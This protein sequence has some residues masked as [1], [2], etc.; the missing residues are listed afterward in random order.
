MTTLGGRRAYTRAELMDAYG[1][2]RSTLEKWYRERERTGHPE[3]AGT[4]G[5]QLV[6]DAAAWDDWYAARGPAVPSGAVS[7]D[8]L[9]ARHGLSRHRLKQLWAD[10]ASNGHPEPAHRA[11]K[12]LYWDE[13]EWTAWYE[14][15]RDRPPQAASG[16]GTGVDD[17]VTLA[18]AAR[19]LGLAQTSVTVYPKRPPAGWPEPARVERLGGGRVRRLYRRAD[20]A[21]YGER[22]LRA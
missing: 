18:E 22:R 21:A 20:I 11:G 2:G 4:I 1:L 6:W 13:A 17:L 3:P 10:R 8:E 7:R 19:I 9:A 12:A 5:S 14:A 16:S 15:H